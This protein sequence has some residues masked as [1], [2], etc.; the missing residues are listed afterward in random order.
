MQ[1]ISYSTLYNIKYKCFGGRGGADV[2]AVAQAT[3]HYTSISCRFAE[4]T[5]GQLGNQTH[6]CFSE[7]ACYGSVVSSR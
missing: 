6:S 1:M 4:A 5:E 3:A 2:W 7:P